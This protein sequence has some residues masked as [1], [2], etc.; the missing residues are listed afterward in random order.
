MYTYNVS[1]S[2]CLSGE[3]T[4]KTNPAV[5]LSANRCF[6]GAISGTIISN[7][8][9]PIVGFGSVNVFVKTVEVLNFLSN[10]SLK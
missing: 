2:T 3:A 6:A 8:F 1:R 7:I 4:R 10:S 5:F 9:A